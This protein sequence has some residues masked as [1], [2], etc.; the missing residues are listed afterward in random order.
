[1]NTSPLLGQPPL[2]HIE[3][4]APPPRR[5]PPRPK[6][7][8]HPVTLASP[9]REVLQANVAK[10]GLDTLPE[11]LVIVG[12]APRIAARCAGQADPQ[13]LVP[14]GCPITKDRRDTMIGPPLA[15]APA[16]TFSWFLT[17][18]NK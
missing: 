17:T 7:V 16:P 14:T 6:Y 5:R 9:H 13:Y 2:G 4:P 10:G 1:M 11:P 18:T 8:E 12:K 15:P 3:G